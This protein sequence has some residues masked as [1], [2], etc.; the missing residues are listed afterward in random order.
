MMNMSPI[1][2]WGID[3]GEKY[4]YLHYKLCLFSHKKI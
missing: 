4:V 3:G 2:L 1:F